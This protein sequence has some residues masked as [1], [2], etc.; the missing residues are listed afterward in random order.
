VARALADVNPVERVARVADY[1]LVLLEPAVGGGPVDLNVARKVLVRAFVHAVG[2]PDVVR[3]E[4]IPRYHVV[5]RPYEQRAAAV[6]DDLATALGADP[7]WRGLV[8]QL[9]R[10]GG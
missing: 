9:V 3:R 5:A 8:A 6:E 1:L 2:G 4:C 7:L 10:N